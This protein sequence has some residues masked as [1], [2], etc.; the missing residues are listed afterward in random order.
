MRVE[1]FSLFFPPTLVLAQARGDRVRDRGDP[2]G[3]LREDHRDEPGRGPPRGGPRPGLPRAAGV[4]ADRGDRRGPGGEPA[5]RADPAVLL[6]RVHRAARPPTTEVGPIEKGYPAAAGAQGGR[7]A[8][9][10]GRRA[11]RRREALAADRQAQVRREA[12]HEG[13]RGRR[14]GH[15][16]RRARRAPRDDRGH[17]DLRPRGQK[18]TRLGFGYAPGPRE[19]LGLGES[20]H[21]VARQ[22]LVHHQ[23][24][25]S[26]CRR[27]SSTPRSAR[28]SRASSAP[29]RSPARRS[30]ATSRR[31]SGSSR[32]SRCRWRS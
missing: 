30:S 21:G 25:A 4:E 8:D 20:R 26:R 19:T 11:R 7:Q 13:L 16:A 31:W 23:A 17:A 5:R 24:D 15:A 14:P 9:R 29:T 12:A 10:R 18:R 27:A 3:R 1:K 6:L 22:L 2:R 32:S 28:R